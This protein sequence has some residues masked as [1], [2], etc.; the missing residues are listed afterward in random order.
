MP[1]VSFWFS[2]CPRTTNLKQ[3]PNL[4]STVYTQQDLLIKASV[5]PVFLLALN[6]IL[7]G[8]AYWHDGWLFGFATLVAFLLFF[9]HWPVNNAISLY[10]NRIFPDYRQA[11]KRIFLSLPLLLLSSGTT[12]LLTYAVLRG[13]AL[14]GHQ[15]IEGRLLWALGFVLATVLVV[16]SIYESINFFE[17]WE[18]TIT[19]TERL[20]KANLQSQFESLKQQINPHFLFNS[21]N[22][23][24]SLIEE[25]PRQAEVFLEEL[26]SVYRYL[27]RANE[28]QLTPLREEL[29]FVRSYFYLLQIRY[30]GGIELIEEVNPAFANHL[31][32]PLT[33]QLLI[34]NAVKHNAILPE[35][36]LVIELHTDPEGWLVV[37][38]TLQRKAVRVPSNRVGLTNIA[39]KYQLLG[40]GAVNVREDETHF[41]VTL[42]LLPSSHLVT[43]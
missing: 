26:A 19:E 28:N 37:R 30:G 43:P 29:D 9:A 38:N 2:N 22:S 6:T 7:L 24:S 36:P 10:F 3:V 32:P 33:L 15:P 14:N 34:E 20:K 41:T 11:A 27:L 4:K 40:Q 13:V 1:A 35:Q 18:R 39:T 8:R 42:P 17:Q 12:T 21:L 16:S 25:D 5:L 31:I 23:L